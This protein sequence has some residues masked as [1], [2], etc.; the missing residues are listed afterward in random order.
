MAANEPM[1]RVNLIPQDRRQ[2]AHNR[3]LIKRWSAGCGAYAA[4]LVVIVSL[5]RVLW[6][7]DT[8]GIQDAIQRTQSEVQQSTAAEHTLLAAVRL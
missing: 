6:A 8:D 2:A 5:G 3:A 4:V 7:D 1:I